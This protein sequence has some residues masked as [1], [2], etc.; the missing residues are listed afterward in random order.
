M[1]YIKT[2]LVIPGASG[3][4]TARR[5][6]ARPP[7]RPSVRCR[8]K[9]AARRAEWSV[10]KKRGTLLKGSRE[11]RMRR[12]ADPL[13]PPISPPLLSPLPPPP[14]P[15]AWEGVAWGGCNLLLLRLVRNHFE[16][17]REI[18]KRH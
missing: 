14:R 1:D 4:A 17:H 6:P 15:P 3:F 16:S 2:P 12:V 18:K 13:L 9:R 5:P 8:A 11:R 10:I 7:A